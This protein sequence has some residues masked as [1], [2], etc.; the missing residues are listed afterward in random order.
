LF[1][2]GQSAFYDAFL[3]LSAHF[4]AADPPN[5]ILRH[6]VSPQSQKDRLTG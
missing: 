4:M 3:L 5:D 2:R 1:C 6:F